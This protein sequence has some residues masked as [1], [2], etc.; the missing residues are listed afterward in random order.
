MAAMFCIAEMCL[1]F[2]SAMEACARTRKSSSVSSAT[3]ASPALAIR[4]SPANRAASLRISTFSSASRATT[5]ASAFAMRCPASAPWRACTPSAQSAW[6]RGS[7]AWPASAAT[8]VNES[9]AL[10]PRRANSKCAR[11]RMRISGCAK[12][13]RRSDSACLPNPSRTRFCAVRIFTS[14]IRVGSH[15]VN[16]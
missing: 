10:A 4:A 12:H 2:P 9:V 7:N 11:W 15:T 5:A 8:F 14:S 16:I 6:N 3:S 13:C 1:I